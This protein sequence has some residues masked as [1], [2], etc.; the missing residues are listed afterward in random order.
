MLNLLELRLVPSLLVCLVLPMTRSVWV[1]YF[2][3][4]ASLLP[5]PYYFCCDDEVFHMMTKIIFF[6]IFLNFFRND[7]S[8]D[9]WLVKPDFWL[10]FG[11][12]SWKRLGKTRVTLG[13]ERHLG[14]KE[15]ENEPITWVVWFSMFLFILK[16]K[17]R[18]NKLKLVFFRADIKHLLIFSQ[19]INFFPSHPCLFFSVF[20]LAIR[21]FFAFQMSCKKKFF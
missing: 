15:M 1:L 10:N 20:V 19:K 8:P 14:V 12:F 9:R 21:F 5:S 18:E 13:F 4:V 6:W 3:I 17:S 7:Y 16:R 11:V 2:T